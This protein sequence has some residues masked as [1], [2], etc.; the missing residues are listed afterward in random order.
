[1]SQPVIKYTGSVSL[2]AGTPYDGSGFTL[3]NCMQM[4]TKG[5]NVSINSMDAFP[6]TYDD[7]GLVDITATYTFNIDCIIAFGDVVEVT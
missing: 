3:G 4:K 2:T 7:I 6:I 1:M 5:T